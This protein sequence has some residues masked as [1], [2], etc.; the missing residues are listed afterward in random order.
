MSYLVSKMILIFKHF[1]QRCLNSPSQGFIWNLNFVTK[2]IF[3]WSQQFRKQ[4]K[5][6]CLEDLAYFTWIQANEEGKLLFPR[7]YTWKMHHGKVCQL[8]CWSHIPFMAIATFSTVS[9]LEPTCLSL[10]QSRISCLF[11]MRKISQH[12]V[13]YSLIT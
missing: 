11:F 4:S 8:Y 10:I 2:R 12:F 7:F 5:C 1:L 6:Y 9:K 13:V 3:A